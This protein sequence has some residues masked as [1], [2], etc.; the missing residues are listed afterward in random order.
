MKRIIIAIIF[1][2]CL[3]QSFANDLDSCK[4]S[5]YKNALTDTATIFDH[6]IGFKFKSKSGKIIKAIAESRS[7]W[8]FFSSRGYSFEGYVNLMV[9]VTEN[10]QVI[11]FSGSDI[12]KNLPFC[13]ARPYKENQ[14]VLRRGNQIAYHYIVYNAE[15]NPF[16]ANTCADIIYAFW[17][18]G[19]G[20]IV[21]ENSSVSLSR[22]GNC[23]GV[24]DI[25]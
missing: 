16:I 19:I 17:L 6:Y 3:E 23:C 20:I 8:Y 13:N 21:A 10:N 25:P 24:K 14:R 4:H 2:F 18:E 15:H 22:G 9:E 1:F 7:L 5:F 12:E 11:P